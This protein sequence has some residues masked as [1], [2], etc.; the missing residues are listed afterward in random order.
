VVLS[1]ASDRISLRAATATAS[2][3]RREGARPCGSSKSEYPSR[4]LI[5]ES[6]SLIPFA[7]FRRETASPDTALEEAL[8]GLGKAMGINLKEMP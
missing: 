7:D 3:I 1:L 4:P 6:Q 5:Q 8:L 2:L